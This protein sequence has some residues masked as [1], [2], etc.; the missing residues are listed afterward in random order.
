MQANLKAT[1]LAAALAA[2]TFASQA[3]PSTDA[4]P[5]ESGDRPARMQERARQHVARRAAELK[6][7]LK[8][9]AE[10]ESAW[11]TYLAAMKP[12][13]RPVQP[14]A[15]DVARMTTPERLDRLRELRKQRDAEFDQREAAT[16][17]FYAALTAEQKKIFDDNTAH[18]FSEGSQRGPR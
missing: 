2:V 17:T 5:P 14:S 6:A 3:Q 11:A 10:Q 18:P 15:E 12:P 7:Q 4:K 1:V 9:S 8:L 13:A 16:R